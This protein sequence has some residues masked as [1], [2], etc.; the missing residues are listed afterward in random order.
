LHWKHFHDVD[1]ITTL[2]TFQFDR[3]FCWTDTAAEVYV[4]Y[5]LAEKFTGL[6]TRF[7]AYEKQ[8]SPQGQADREEEARSISISAAQGE[9]RA[10]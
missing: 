8:Q 10:R 6:F 9:A 7:N 4:L 1:S 3:C 5:R 2:N